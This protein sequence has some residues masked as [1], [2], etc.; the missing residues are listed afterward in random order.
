VNFEQLV[1]WTAKQAIGNA[2]AFAHACEVVIEAEFLP[3]SS[4]SAKKRQRVSEGM[5]HHLVSPDADNIAKAVLD[6]LNGTVWV[7]DKQVVCLTV[8][9]R[10]GTSDRTNVLIR[11]LD[12]KEITA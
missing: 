6:G 12:V 3:P 8:K 1:A 5:E 2:P 4:W 9:K 11:V 7:D 10:Y